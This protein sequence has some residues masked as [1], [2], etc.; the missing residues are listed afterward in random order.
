M[1]TEADVPGPIEFLMSD[2][3]GAVTGHNLVADGGWILW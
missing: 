3:A 1:L 2:G